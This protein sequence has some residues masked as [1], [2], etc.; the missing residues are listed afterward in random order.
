MDI[1][2]MGYKNLMVVLITPR[3][4]IGIMDVMGY[5]MDI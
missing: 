5:R 4:I 2:L 1:F 3:H